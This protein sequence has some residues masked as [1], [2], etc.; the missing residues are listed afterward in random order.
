MKD[1]DNI[2][3]HPWKKEGKRFDIVGKNDVVLVC[4]YSSSSDMATEWVKEIRKIIED[5]KAESLEPTETPSSNNNASI[6]PSPIP[7]QLNFSVENG[8]AALSSPIKS[9][10]PK[11]RGS[12]KF[13]S[14]GPTAEEFLHQLDQTSSFDD[15]NYIPVNADFNEF[16]IVQ[17]LGEGMFGSLYLSR[18]TYKDKD[19]MYFLSVIDTNSSEKVQ[20]R[21]SEIIKSLSNFYSNFLLEA[22][23]SGF[24]KVTQKSWIAFSYFKGAS[25]FRLV[26]S[27][28]K[29]SE[30]IVK[31]IAAK[32]VLCI[33]FLHRKKMILKN[34]DTEHV[35]IDSSGHV[36]FFDLRYGCESLSSF[37]ST[38]RLAEYTP[39]EYLLTGSDD[40]VSD[41]WRLGI[42]IYELLNGY[43]PFRSSNIDEIRSQ[44]LM[45]SRL[46]SLY[47]GFS[48]PSRSFISKCL[49]IDP[50]KRLGA[51]GDSD[52][53]TA[54][55]FFDEIDWKLLVSKN[56]SQNE[57][58]A[59]VIS[60]FDEDLRCQALAF[61]VIDAFVL[62]PANGIIKDVKSNDESLSIYYLDDLSQDPK[63]YLSE[64]SPQ[65]ALPE[66]KVNEKKEEATPR[67]RKTSVRKVTT[68]SE[69]VV[70]NSGFDLDQ[71]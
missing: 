28:I 66:I 8:S 11:K 61:G 37:R 1:V 16:Q 34:L 35:F 3:W 27:N 47:K 67:T 43:P 62:K 41:W 64:N 29:F 33:T 39:P 12:P 2:R 6:S 4:F 15:F 19:M 14:D 23:L 10:N 48:A 65:R 26:A 30:D 5:T 18:R 55:P 52:E 69:E 17:N 46:D 63:K 54:H 31:Y 22:S 21:G 68:F 56:E 32:L 20:K 13:Y 36:M 42:L 51:Q 45:S 7:F 38:S 58:L 71:K 53:V 50:K 25:L 70:I 59:Q 57:F 49:E 24:D 44:I 60:K 9:T 40:F